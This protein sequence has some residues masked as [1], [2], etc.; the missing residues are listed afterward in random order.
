LWGIADIRKKLN[1]DRKRVGRGGGIAKEGKNFLSLG[2][3]RKRGG[4]W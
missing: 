3:F 4:S 2:M 1:S